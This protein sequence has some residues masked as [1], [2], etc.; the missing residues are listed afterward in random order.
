[1]VAQF[2]AELHLPLSKLRLESYR[3]SGG[4]DLA[5]IARYFWD[6]EL[7]RTLSP[8]LHAVELALRNSTHHALAARFHDEMW[9]YRPGLL[10]PGQLS[11]LAGA[12]RAISDRK[13]DATPGRIVAELSFGFWSTLLTSRYEQRLWQPHGFALLRTVFPHA[14]GRSIQQIQ[15]HY[16]QL[17][18]LRNRV[19]H[20]E[21]I[22]DRPDLGRDYGNVLTAIG[23]IS[24]RLRDSI[25]EF[26]EFPSIYSNADGYEHIERRLISHIGV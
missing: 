2:V 12:L 23:W 11:Q 22:W 21:A 15:R 18:T 8:A 17:R 25:E 6:M 14:T 7:A 26:S 4:S 13:A 24:P 3:P 1:M 10:E 5:M 19:S 20:Y 9:F 16:N